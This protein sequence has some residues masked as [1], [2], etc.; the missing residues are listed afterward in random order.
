MSTFIIFFTIG[1]IFCFSLFQRHNLIGGEQAVIIATAID[2]KLLRLNTKKK[3]KKKN[4]E[5]EKSVAHKED[6]NEIKMCYVC[7]CVKDLHFSP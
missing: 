7:V 2:I 4:T 5:K 1:S 6:E 3:T